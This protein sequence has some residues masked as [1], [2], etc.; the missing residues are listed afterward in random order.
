MVTISDVAALAAQVKAGMDTLGQKIDAVVTAYNGGQGDP[1]VL[2]QAMADLQA[3]NDEEQAKGAEI[4]NAL[5]PPAPPPS[6]PP[7]AA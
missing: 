6:D 2:A 5:A 7:P 3:A 4:D 1:A